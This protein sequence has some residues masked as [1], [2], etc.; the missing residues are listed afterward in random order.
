MMSRRIPQVICEANR[1]SRSSKP[2]TEADVVDSVK[3]EYEV[4][5]LHS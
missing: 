2:E 4:I 1:R 5:L 3:A